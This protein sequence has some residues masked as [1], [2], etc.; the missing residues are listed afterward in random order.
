MARNIENIPGDD[1]AQDETH[2]D[3]LTGDAL[4][5]WLGDKL[6]DTRKPTPRQLLALFFGSL[7]PAEEERVRELLR[8]S[9]ASLEEYAQ[10]TGHPLADVTNELNAGFRPD[11]IL[12]N[13][14]TSLR[15]IVR[16]IAIAAT[17]P[18]MALA[19]RGDTPAVTVYEV[20]GEP[21]V[22]IIIEQSL[23]SL[24]RYRVTVQVIIVTGDSAGSGEYLLSHDGVPHAN[25]NIGP[26][27]TFDLGVLQ[28]GIYRLECLIGDGVIELPALSIGADTGQPGA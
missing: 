5:A 9:P 8:R 22:S 13:L 20:S 12:A 28:A 4:D 16:R 21:E 26:T 24:R 23:Q 27:G 14:A 10:L 18:G 15:E 17:L 6:R 7:G 3:I 19:Y 11:D 1:P 25:G 2:S